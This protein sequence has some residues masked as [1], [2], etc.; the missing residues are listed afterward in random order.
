[1]KHDINNG[2]TLIETPI[3]WGPEAAP[4]VI[5]S[6]HRR[7]P[8]NLP[9]DVHE[10]LIAAGVIGDPVVGL[11]SFD[12]EWIEDRA[13][14]FTREIELTEAQRNV[15]ALELEFESLDA[16]ADVF[17]NGVHLGHH[18]SAH[19]PF[20]ADVLRFSRTGSNTVLVRLT[21][22]ADRYPQAQVSRHAESVHKTYRRGDERRVFVR[23]P[24]YVYG[25][26]WGPRVAT[27]GIVKSVSL[28][29]ISGCFVRDVAVTTQRATADGEEAI[30]VVTVSVEN[31]HPIRTQDA[32]VA[33]RMDHPGA[34]SAEADREVLLRS[35]SNEVSFELTLA[36]AQLW[37]PSGMGGQARYDV[38]VEVR[39][40]D[41]GGTQYVR[42]L[43]TRYGV[44]T[45]TLN[46]DR[47]P[48][49]RRFAFE[50]NGRRVF[51][52]GGN[53]IPAD[54][55]YSRVTDEKYRRL[56][57][58]AREANFTM[59]RIWGGGI[60]E[61]DVFYELCDEMG[62]LVWQDLM[63]ACATYPDEEE[64]FREEARREI[65]YQ[66]RRLRNR[67]CIAVISG[68]NENQWIYRNHW[69]APGPIEYTAGSVVYNRIAPEIVARNCPAI[70]YWN[71]S[72][73]GGDD[74]NGN[75]VGDRHHWHDCTM[76]PEMQKRITPEEYDK[77]TSK[78]ISE[79]GY[80][81]P[82]SR[83]TIE[84]YHG[85]EP[86][87]RGSEVWDWH[88]N[89]F[90]KDTV[91]AGIAKHYTDPDALDLDGYLYYAS[92]CQALMLGYSLEAIRSKVDCY[93]AL[94][95]MYNDCWG[96]VGWTIID[97]YLDR[98]PAFYAVKR[99]FA[100]RRMILR[101]EA[102][103]IAL[104]VANDTPEQLQ[105]E[106][107]YGMVPLDR[108]PTDADLT[109]MSI[110]VAP[111]S[112]HKTIL[113]PPDDF[114]DG[115]ESTRSGS[116]AGGLFAVIPNDSEVLPAFLRPGVFRSLALPDP[117]VTTSVEAAAG[118]SWVTVHSDTYAHAVH[119]DLDVD[120]RP[121]DDYFDL[122]PGET[123][124]VWVPGLSAGV[125]SAM[126][127]P[128]SGVPIDLSHGASHRGPA[129]T[130]GARR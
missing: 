3:D 126:A 98:K 99:A 58:E 129:A 73:Y 101:R 120:A 108:V 76:N 125:V 88:N 90:E 23:K 80:I 66:T 43:E 71:S 21:H 110:S 28:H 19:Y 9:C 27:C 87:V 14:W 32:V 69:S 93:G 116:S 41:E 105:L 63:F 89:T 118:G 57:E 113:A 122:L 79:Y 74:P 112:R 22:G 48:T 29:E 42:S 106:C 35:G 11:N 100:P 104:V 103:G 2:W 36:Q 70:P 18:R 128:P 85:G 44:R 121:D 1:M 33:V 84:R 64:W 75:D 83:R 16:E 130:E 24:Q 114:N 61:R 25:W 59:L 102:D 124:R 81:G 65:E 12:S 45:L 86:I 82:C 97:Y 26:D 37:W 38:H 115:L 5:E 17:F 62:I 123:R 92:L 50:V 10:P 31:T 117:K 52:R 39:T 107:R 72:P 56:I 49:G 119:L 6:S 15:A 127:C 55:V 91:V 77:I 34:P 68:N 67:A 60:Y 46:L 94:F 51:C 78:F 4:R 47:L 54:S 109:T 111:F 53:W 96:E 7:F 13:W 8:V 20:V 40:N 30:V 95:W